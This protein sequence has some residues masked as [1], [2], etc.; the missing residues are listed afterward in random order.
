MLPTRTFIATFIVLFL[1]ASLS[2]AEPD[3]REKLETLIPAGIKHYAQAKGETV[4]QI[5]G[6]GPFDI[7]WANP[8]ED[9]ARSAPQATAK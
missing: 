3:P 4:I 7:R 8:D 1:C 5:S 6:T 9:P 2:A